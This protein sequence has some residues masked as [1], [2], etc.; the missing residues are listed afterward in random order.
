[1]VDLISFGFIMANK[2]GSITGR[3][4][5]ARVMQRERREYNIR[6]PQSLPVNLLFPQHFHYGDSVFYIRAS[7]ISM[8]KSMPELF[9][10]LPLVNALERGR[11][12]PP[13]SESLLPHDPASTRGG[14]PYSNAA[15]SPELFSSTLDSFP[16]SSN[17]QL[18]KTSTGWAILILLSAR[19]LHRY[20]AISTPV[21][22][23]CHACPAAEGHS[24][25]CAATP[26]AQA[27]PAACNGRHSSMAKG[28]RCSA[29]ELPDAA[30]LCTV[31]LSRTRQR[32]AT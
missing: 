2:F 21:A 18:R 11:R 5:Y 30:T 13:L 23:T 22:R 4:R 25:V 28:S 27:P 29:N 32:R 7:I 24:L 9:Y 26:H 3:R 1:M 6:G 12:H 17:L 15:P 10:E 20:E 31:Q 19:S 16:S 8:D 14:K